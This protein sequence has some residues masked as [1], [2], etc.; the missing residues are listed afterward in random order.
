MIIYPQGLAEHL[1]GTVTTL[2]YCW[3]VV[4]ADGTVLGFTD[5]DRP[6]SFGGIGHEPQSGF[7]ASEARQSLGLS[8]DTVDV[9][10]A[11]SS[12]AITD[13]DID[14]GRYDRA[15]VETWLANWNAP[16]DA[17]LLQVYTIGKITRSDGTFR[18]ELRN[19]AGD[20]DEQRGRYYRRQCSARL[21]DGKCGVDLS[22]S[23]YNGS[24]I[25]TSASALNIFA[26]TGLES[27]SSG[28][29]ANG[30]LTWMSGANAGLTQRMSAHRI[31]SAGVQIELDEAPPR[32]VS[33][34]DTFDAKAGCDKSFASCKARF[35]NSANFRGFPHL[36]GTDAAYNYATGGQVF[37]GRPLVS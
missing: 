9:E 32:G 19:L 16:Q 18:A 34:G 14:A 2:C 4:L 22:G 30:E 6:L 37:D 33:T 5:H 15:R 29:F 26:V 11:L 8:T 25:V 20:Y 7:S 12:D 10:G 36:P 27:F 1:S 21:G 24:A 28:W 35:G 3:R 17:A 23:S 31:T 13:E